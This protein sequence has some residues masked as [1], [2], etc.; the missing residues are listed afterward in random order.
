MALKDEIRIIEET[1]LYYKL[2]L[3]GDPGAGKTVMA[4][5]APE[6]IWFDSE[7]SVDTLRFYPEYQGI[8][9]IKLRSIDGSNRANRWT[10]VKKLVKEAVE[11]GSYGTIVIDTVKGF[12]DICVDEI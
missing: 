10:K 3:A 4:A 12:S 2:L 7:R 1:D 11:C 8:P 5:G 6:P 9:Y